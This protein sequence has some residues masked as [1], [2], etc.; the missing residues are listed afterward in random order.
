LESRSNSCVRCVLVAH[1]KR[2]DPR[3]SG[4]QPLG[5][6]RCQRVQ[7]RVQPGLVPTAQLPGITGP[8]QPLHPLA[9]QPYV[10]QLLPG[11]SVVHHRLAG[12]SAEPGL[13]A[14]QPVLLAL[15]SGLL[16]HEPQLF[17][18]QPEL[19]ADESEL[20]PHQPQLLADESKLLAHQPELQPDQS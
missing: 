6:V 3:R 4:V 18:D 9:R 10:A 13:L 12:H 20:L 11:I 19:L 2:D 16:A 8:D 1:G 7:P 17:P 15:E 5:P 14:H